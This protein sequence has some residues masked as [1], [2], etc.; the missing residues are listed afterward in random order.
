MRNDRFEI[1][2]RQRDIPL[3]ANQKVRLSLASVL[4]S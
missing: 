2:N 4:K 1:F 3:D